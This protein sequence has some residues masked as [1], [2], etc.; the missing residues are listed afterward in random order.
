MLLY[1]QIEEGTHSSGGIV[2][3]K[4]NTKTADWMI[5]ETF[6][7]IL[8]EQIKEN[9][10]AC[11]VSFKDPQYTATSGGYHPVEVMIG[12]TG[13]IHYIT[14][15]TYVGQPPYEQL[16]KE[17]DFDFSTGA[18]RHMGLEYP[19]SSGLGLYKIWESNFC[20]YLRMGVFQTSVEEI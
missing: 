4:V 8:Y 1:I 18:L 9:S 17:I 13:D 16:V 11:I 2:M 19:L 5:S 12:T 14:D 20:G 10:G 7:N 3:T 15:Y 6:Q